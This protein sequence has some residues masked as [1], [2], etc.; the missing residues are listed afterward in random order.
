MH[1]ALNFNGIVL[2][3]KIYS[4]LLLLFFKSETKIVLHI[5][6]YSDL[7]KGSVVL[8][9]TKHEIDNIESCLKNKSYKF[10]W[11]T[12]KC[13]EYT[14]CVYTCIVCRTVHR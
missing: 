1:F 11:S 12:I 2:K 9:S 3:N 6:Y 4:I 14:I 10:Y 7:K 13:S 5:L 8:I